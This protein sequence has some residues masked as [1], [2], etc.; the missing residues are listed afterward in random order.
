MTSRS[1]RWVSGVGAV[2]VGGGLLIASYGSGV[3]PAGAA[4]SVDPLNGII[5]KLDQILAALTSAASTGYQTLRW[6][7]NNPSATRFVV[8]ASFNNQAVLDKNTGLVWEQAPSTATGNWG[9]AITYCADKSVGGTRG[10]RLP[11]VIELMSVQ[12]PSLAPPF[13]PAPVFTNVQ[14]VDYWSAS[15]VVEIPSDA[16]TVSFIGDT[17]FANKNDRG[18]FVPAW[19]VRGGMNASAY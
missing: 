9:N 1:S 17:R 3:T 11:S 7:N 14:S 16:W 10:W 5:A 15:V 18:G 12:D 19:C 2:L 13:V 6:D 4:P 8:L